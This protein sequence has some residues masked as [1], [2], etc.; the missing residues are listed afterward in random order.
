MPVDSF[1]FSNKEQREYQKIIS[2][3]EWII[4]TSDSYDEAYAKIKKLK[5]FGKPI[6]NS[7]I[8]FILESD[9]TLN[10]NPKLKK[11]NNRDGKKKVTKSKGKK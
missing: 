3:S 9:N 5:L 2:K 10:L 11:R 1:K 4:K 8:R 6:Y 7:T